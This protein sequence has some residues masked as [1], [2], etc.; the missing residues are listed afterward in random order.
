MKKLVAAVL[1]AMAMAPAAGAHSTGSERRHLRRRKWTPFRGGAAP[2]VAGDVATGAAIAAA[3]PPVLG[4]SGAVLHGR[5]VPYY[6]PDG[7]PA[8]GANSTRPPGPGL[9]AIGIAC[10]GTCLGCV[11]SSS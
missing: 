7:D 2:R 8:K 9:P 6:T 4:R 5:G 11:N 1:T 3:E 10:G